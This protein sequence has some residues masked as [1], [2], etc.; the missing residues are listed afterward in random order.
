M[1]IIETHSH[2]NGLEFL[3]IR[4]PH[5]REEIKDVI[6]KINAEVCG[7]EMSK[8]KGKFLYSPIK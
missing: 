1:K 7:T 2:L 3:L 6:G 8:Q 4:K 5:L